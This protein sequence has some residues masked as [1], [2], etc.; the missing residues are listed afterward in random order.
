M[1]KIEKELTQELVKYLF[2]YKDGVLYWKNPQTN[3]NKVGSIAG[4]INKKEFRS[5]VMIG[6]GYKRYIASR[7][8]FL[9]HHGFLPKCVDHID[10][11][12][13][14]DR[15]ENLRGATKR[16]N[17]RNRNPNIGSYSQY[18]GVTFHKR[19]KKWQAQIG[20]PERKGY[21]GVFEKES[22]A[23]LA[24]NKEAVKYFGEFANLNII[25]P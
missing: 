22:D 12:T 11:N 2:D 10:R 3:K 21:I 23:A 6:I 13:L 17:S 9:W 1:A 25:K 16:E 5:R 19:D 18:L 14:N 20:L 7:L 15:I 24:Y 8:I 4:Y